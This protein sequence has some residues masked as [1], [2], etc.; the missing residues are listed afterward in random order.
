MHGEFSVKSDV[1]SFGVLVLEIISG[2][3]ISSFYQTD[4]AEDLVSYVSRANIIVWP[5][6]VNSF[7]LFVSSVKENIVTMSLQML[8]ENLIQ[9]WK[10]WNDGA[11][12]E[13]MDPTLRESYNQNEVI[14][15][16]HIG[17]LCVQEDP[18]DRPTMA[19]IILM[20]DSNTVTLPAPKQPAFLAHSETDANMPRDLMF[21]QSTSKSITASVNEMSVSEVLPR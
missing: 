15:C 20:L 11:P 2:K 16:I 17:L 5:Y 19:T 7:V 3:K 6:L 9:A 21:G 10:L 18:A 14:R 8:D 4:V 13:L 1:Y 12:L